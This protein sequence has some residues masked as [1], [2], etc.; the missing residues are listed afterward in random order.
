MAARALDW[1]R[2]PRRVFELLAAWRPEVV[3][4]DSYAATTEFLTELGG[5]VPQVT[6]VDDLADRK[7]PVALVVNGGYA[8][9]GLTYRVRPDTTLLLG[10]AY[11]LLD[12]AFAVEP[13]R[14][15]RGA[16]R[17]VLVT[18]GGDAPAPRLEAVAAAVRHAAPEASVDVVVGPYAPGVVSAGERVTVHRGLASLR[19][20]ILAAD[21]AVT[22]GGVTVYECLASATPVIASCLADNQRPNVD[23]L[24]R[25]GLILPGGPSLAG[26]L[27]RLIDDAELRTVLAARGRAAVDGAGA[28]RVATALVRARVA[29]GAARRV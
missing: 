28:S 21:L 23:A 2:E 13:P 26:A 18:L 25:A 11:A 1:L 4:V 27:A 24:G 5:V 22:G 9:A 16:V 20:L 8:A 17:R 29:V 14:R 3:V 7:L 15:P 19:P 10:P 6:V 12:P